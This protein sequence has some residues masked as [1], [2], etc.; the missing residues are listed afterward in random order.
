VFSLFAGMMVLQLIRVATM[1]PEGVPLK[2][3]QKQLG[4]EFASD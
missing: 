1:I 4:M 2:Q 3:I